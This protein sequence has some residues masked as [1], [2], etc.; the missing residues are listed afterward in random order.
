MDMIRDILA[1]LGG[2]FWMIL[3]F[4]LIIA[5]SFGG[6]YCFGTMFMLPFVW[7]GLIR[8]GI[9]AACVLGV[10]GILRIGREKDDGP[11]SEDD[12]RP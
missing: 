4:I 7:D 2:T 1:V 8:L 6:C 3:K 11:V 9:T 10:I 5:L 12:F